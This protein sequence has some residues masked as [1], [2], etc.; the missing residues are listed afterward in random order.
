MRNNGRSVFSKLSFLKVIL[1]L[2]VIVIVLL[3]AV[4]AIGK[5]VGFSYEAPNVK[6]K[7]TAPQVLAVQPKVRTT[8][9]GS[10]VAFGDDSQAHAE[11]VI[12][13]NVQPPSAASASEVITSGNGSP[14]AYGKNSSAETKVEARK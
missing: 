12:S 4:Y 2:G 14:V 10:P 6:I 7:V 13:N 1:P 5:K 8:G 11:G 3:V 9:A